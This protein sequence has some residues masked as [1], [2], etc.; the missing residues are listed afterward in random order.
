MT[1][2]SGYLMRAGITVSELSEK[3]LSLEE[4]FINITGDG[5]NG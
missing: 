4:Y 1:E 2:L 3:E 5:N